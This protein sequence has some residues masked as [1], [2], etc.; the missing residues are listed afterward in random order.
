MHIF[1]RP[2]NG[3]V[4]RARW[5]YECALEPTAP[6]PY[7]IRVITSSASALQK[8]LSGPAA[9]GWQLVS[10]WPEKE[11]VV[12]VFQRAAAALPVVAPQAPRAAS[13]PTPPESPAAP[14]LLD[15][16][17]QLCSGATQKPGKNGKLLPKGMPILGLARKLG[18]EPDKLMAALKAAGVQEKSGQSDHYHKGTFIWTT[19]GDPQKGRGFV[20]IRPAKKSPP[21]RP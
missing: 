9:E 15:Q 4:L 8:D 17:I 6:M 10:C 21:T 16:V 20:N 3:F 11:K 19:T 7:E 1:R 14:D 2:K 18:M 13:V 5:L 12:A